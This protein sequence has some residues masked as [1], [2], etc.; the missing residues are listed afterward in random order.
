MQDFKIRKSIKRFLKAAFALVLTGTLLTQAP[1]HAYAQT[2]NTNTNDYIS[3]VKIAMG[4]DAEDAL[5]GYTILKGE[6][7][8]A[9]DLNKDAG[10]RPAA[11]AVSGG[12]RCV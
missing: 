11:S 4:G 6:D 12:V 2:Q 10:H 8:K 3:D 5:E 9:V 7:G 1:A